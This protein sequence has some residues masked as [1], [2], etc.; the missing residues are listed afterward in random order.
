[1][2]KC[3]KRL[4]NQSVVYFR[5][6]QIPGC[7]YVCY[8]KHENTYFRIRDVRPFPPIHRQQSRAAATAALSSRPRHPAQ[9]I[10]NPRAGGRRTAMTCPLPRGT[11]RALTGRRSHHLPVV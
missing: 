10:N 11:V 6:F 9:M 5:L 1:M 7:L 3:F 8:Q 4:L 2:K